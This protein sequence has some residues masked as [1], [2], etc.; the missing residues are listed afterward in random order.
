MK[1]N[2]NSLCLVF[3]RHRKFF[4][5]I[6]ISLFLAFVSTLQILAGNS[7]SQ[8]TRL[9]LN[10][11]DA[12][13]KEVLSQIEEQSGIYFLYDNGLIDVYKKVDIA[14]QNE[15]IST[16]VDQLF[17]KGKITTVIRD[18]HV[19][20]SPAKAPVAPQ[21][22]NISGRVVDSTGDALPGVSVFEK[23]TTNGTITNSEGIYTLTNFSSD[24]ILIFSFIGM[25]DQEVPVAG[26]TTINVV[27]VEEAITIDEVV[28]IGY[29]TRRKSSLAG[30]ISS[31]QS[32][33]LTIAPISSASNALTGRLPGLITVQSEGRPGADAATLNIR[34][35]GNPLVIVDGVEGDLNLLDPNSIESISVLKDGSASIYGARAGNGVVLVST[36]RGNISKPVF[37]LNTSFSGQGITNF[38]KTVSSGQYAEMQREAYLQAGKPE[39]NA[40]Y[41]EEDIRMFYDGSDPLYHPNTDWF[42]L[43]IRDWAP[44]QEHNISVRG[45]SERIK[46]YGFLG[47]LKQETLWKK[48]GGDFQRYNFQS[49]VDMKLTDNLDMKIDVSS[50]VRDL[51][52]TK[53]NMSRD[54]PELWQDL[55][56]SNPMYRSDFPEDD[57]LP[58]V[59]TNY[60]AYGG[61][62]RD[63]G[64]YNDTDFQRVEGTFALNYD[65]NFIKGLS[66]KYTWHYLKDYTKQKTFYGGYEMWNYAYEDDIYTLQA[67]TRG[68]SA[69]SLRK[70]ESQILTSQFSLNYDRRFNVD[71]HLTVLALYESIGYKSDYLYTRRSNFITS[72][73]DQLY[74]GDSGTSTNDGTASEMGRKSF[75]GRL[76]YSFKDKYLLEAIFRADASAKFPSD[77]RWGYFP[78]ILLAWRLSEENFIADLG[79]FDNLK[80]KAS[81][82]QSGNDGVGNFQYLTGYS[83][84]ANYGVYKFGSEYNAGL[85]TTGLA[86]PNLTWE[87]I[88]LYNVGAEFSMWRRKLYGEMDVFY[89]EREGIP[90]TRILS[91]PNTFG[92]SLPPENINSLNNRGF[93]FK[94]GTAGEFPKFTWDISA[95]VAWSRAKWMH[96]EEPD[97]EDPDQKR[98]SKRSGRWTD[99]T[100]GYKS[101]HLFT[102]Q[103]EIDNLEFDQD[104]QGNTSLR[105]GD[106]KY[107]DVNDDGVLNWKDQVEIGKGQLPHW[108]VGI[109]TRFTYGNFDL[110]SLWQGAFGHYTYVDL[111][112]NMSTYY[113]LRWTEA[114][115]N[116]DALVPRLGGAG[117]NGLYSDY[118]FKKAGY[119][120]L[121]TATFGYSLPQRWVER[122]N[123]SKVRLYLAGTNLLT[124]DKLSEYGL[125]PEAPMA[126]SGH[127]AYYYPQQRTVSVGATLTF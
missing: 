51:N 57:K 63:I 36:K 3:F 78:S 5:T 107:V 115:N 30:A 55:W 44:Q 114:N 38:P 33:D 109:N 99:V 94:V 73:L 37:S 46:Y 122:V 42:S 8:S 76:N 39:E 58:Y 90:G 20:L 85:Y 45:G 65:V 125:D 6:R 71:H 13:I 104:Q 108:T 97:Y 47:Y 54:Y 12:S 10:M 7:Y 119:I 59:G 18:G 40:P 61:S 117:T 4:R 82:G 120:R 70:S 124:F 14:V 27:M 43:L 11:K 17:G 105:P 123:F 116:A 50:V 100:F 95:L 101:D 111:T 19:I 66:A 89:R 62:N 32:K 118:R 49:N 113:E 72:A 25:K 80:L 75:V 21:K 2:A 28:A 102:S 22:V 1:K 121:K 87:N 41:S 48:N 23:G 106:I 92:A 127:S 16:V 24:A 110:T 68:E 26:Q 60:P 31:V 84:K 29:G 112:T 83:F 88:S 9:T 74:A 15:E 81:F 103:E 53:R 77:K 35:F 86:N 79:L 56:F 52:E 91:L 93:D 34:G 126:T 96:F 69:L 98:I 64:G 67:D